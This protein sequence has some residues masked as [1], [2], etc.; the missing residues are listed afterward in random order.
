M[1]DPLVPRKVDRVLA[2]LR[3]RIV[4]GFRVLQPADRH[5]TDRDIAD[6]KHLITENIN[7]R[8][9]KKRISNAHQAGRQ[10]VC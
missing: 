10:Q 8:I 6:H 7:F 2:D 9:T 1:S 3:F 4:D 5:V